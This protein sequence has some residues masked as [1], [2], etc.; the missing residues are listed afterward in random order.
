ME[1]AAGHQL[2]VGKALSLKNQPCKKGTLQCNLGLILSTSLAW[3]NNAIN[4]SSF[5][6][7]YFFTDLLKRFK[8]KR[9]GHGIVNEQQQ[10]DTTLYFIPTVNLY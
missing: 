8:K 2:L 6:V 7:C 9:L 3:N 10:R 4:L 1:L 5:G